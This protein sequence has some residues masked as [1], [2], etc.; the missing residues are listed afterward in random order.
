MKQ[1]FPRDS[2]LV[3]ISDLKVAWFGVFSRF[4]GVTICRRE[5]GAFCVCTPKMP[6]HPKRGK[7][8]HLAD[9]LFRKGPETSQAELATTE[10]ETGSGPSPLPV[11]VQFLR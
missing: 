6:V 7:K 3:A 8:S 1:V 2:F 5:T 10:M 4:D 11:G 9:F